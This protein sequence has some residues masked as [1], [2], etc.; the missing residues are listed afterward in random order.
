M[1]LSIGDGVFKKK[2]I[3]HNLQLFR[4][5]FYLH[6]MHVVHAFGFFSEKLG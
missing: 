3:S 6:Q 2:I 5:G 1:E 4:F